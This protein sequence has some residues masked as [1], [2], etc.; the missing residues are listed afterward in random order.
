MEVQTIK[1]GDSESIKNY[2]VD[3]LIRSGFV[4]AL[5]KKTIFPSYIDDYLD[6]FISEVWIAILEQKPTVWNKLYETAKENGTDIEY[7][8]RNYFSRVILNTCR[9]SSSNAY[10]KLIKHNTTE[11]RRNE[12]QWKVYSNSIPDTNGITDT[13]RNM[14][15][16]ETTD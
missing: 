16:K 13:I 10:R 11:L 14:C 12:T 5:T 6:D 4:V 3:Y 1:E 15:D 7:Q 8:A 9:S 2:I